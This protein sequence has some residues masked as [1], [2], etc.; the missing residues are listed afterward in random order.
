VTCNDIFVNSK[1]VKLL[2][3]FQLTVSIMKM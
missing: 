1:Q 2:T 3:E